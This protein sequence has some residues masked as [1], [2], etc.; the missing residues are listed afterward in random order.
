MK[1][2]LNKQ[3]KRLNKRI[4]SLEQLITEKLESI[5]TTVNIVL[6]TQHQQSSTNIPPAFV[7]PPPQPIPPQRSLPGENGT[8]PPTIDPPKVVSVDAD[9]NVSEHHEDSDE[10]DPSIHFLPEEDDTEPPLDIVMPL[11]EG[12]YLHSE[13][14]RGIANQDMNIRLWISTKVSDGNFARSKNHIKQYGQSEFVMMMDNDLILPIGTFHRMISLFNRY[15]KMG[16]IGISKHYV[17]DS[18]HGELEVANHVDAGVMMIR[19]KLL[20]AITYQN[21][22]AC[23]C[24]AFCDDVRKVGYETGYLTGVNAMHILDTR[25]KR[26]TDADFRPRLPE[27]RSSLADRDSQR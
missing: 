4:D 18:S 23:E 20:Q 8:A 15:P 24:L 27:Q 26:R 2:N 11:A 3:V 14:L 1:N 21:R 13:V 22:G 7:E 19:N 17:P 6:A 10:R 9:G 5:Q 12:R 25:F 16:V